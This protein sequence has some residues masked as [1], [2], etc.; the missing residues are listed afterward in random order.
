MNIAVMIISVLVKTHAKS[1]SIVIGND[2]V[3]HAR[4]RAL[5]VEGKANAY[6]CSYLSDVFHVPRSSVRLVSGTRS[7][8][9]RIE[10]AADATALREV[11]DR[12][13]EA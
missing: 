11:I 1:D 6:L 3:L 2:H 10:I 5:P 4:I 8:L 9:K 7:R 12:L 13:K